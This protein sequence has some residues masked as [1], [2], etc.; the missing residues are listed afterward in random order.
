MEIGTFGGDLLFGVDSFKNLKWEMVIFLKNKKD[1]RAL[2]PRV[3]R[4][5]SLRFF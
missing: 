1:N 4:V 2:S 5:V 3:P